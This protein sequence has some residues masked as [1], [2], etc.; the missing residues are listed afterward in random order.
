MISESLKTNTTLRTL[1]LSCDEK[2]SK[3]K[4]IIILIKKT[5]EWKNEM[6][7]INND[8]NTKER[9]SNDKW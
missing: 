1:N 6:K 9:D 4:W 8:E 2:W 3:M 7:N 5:K